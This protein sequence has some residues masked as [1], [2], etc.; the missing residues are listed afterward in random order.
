[1]LDDFASVQFIFIAA[2]LLF[3][4]GLNSKVKS[5]TDRETKDR[6]YI[7]KLKAKVEDISKEKCASQ[8]LVASLRSEVD[9]KNTCLQETQ[10]N[11]TFSSKLAGF[12]CFVVGR[13]IGKVL[14]KDD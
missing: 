10:V 14:N 11:K 7:D 6:A 4:E 1:M 3:L 9:K 12:F 13:L 5:L 8:E 2:L